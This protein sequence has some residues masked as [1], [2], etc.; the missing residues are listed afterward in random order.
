MKPA[1]VSGASGFLGKNLV[2]RLLDDGR[3]VVA[4]LRRDSDGA[5]LVGAA[6]ERHDGTTADLRRIVEKHRPGSVFHL[7]A[8]IS[9][10]Q[11]TDEVEPLVRSNVLFGVQLAEACAT[12]GAV[13]FVNVGTYF[14]RRS[15][16]ETY[17]P[18][19][20]YAATKRAFRDILEYYAIATPL[21]AATVTLYDTYGP[22]DRRPKLL[23]L[24]AS[25]AASGEPILLSPGEQ[26]LDMLHIDDV[27]AAMLRA[28][29]LLGE[30]G[31]PRAREWCASSGERV[32]LRSLVDIFKEATGLSPEVRFGGRPYR[33]REVM[34]PWLGEPVP[35]WKPGIPLKEGLRRVYGAAA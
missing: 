32:S 19:S 17:D 9:G 16:S 26:L 11:S 20:L 21:R 3:P 25:H 2:R 7:A 23:N 30:T 27:C 33:E 35:G 12:A 29:A 14:E 10:E 1:L 34:T 24:L 15:G 13:K 28:E 4:V 18:V 22:G 5:G 31:E 6:L 8:L